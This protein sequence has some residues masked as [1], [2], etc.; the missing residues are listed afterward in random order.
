M[1]PFVR[2][3]DRLPFGLSR[4]I[5]MIRLRLPVWIWKT[6]RYDVI[7]NEMHSGWFCLNIVIRL[8]PWRITARHG[9]HVLGK[10]RRRGVMCP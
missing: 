7:N 5:D 2:H 8:E 1:I 6:E 3:G 4:S 9:W 10:K